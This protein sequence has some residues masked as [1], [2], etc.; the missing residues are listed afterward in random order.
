MLIYTIHPNANEPAIASILPGVSVARAVE[1]ITGR[2]P[3]QGRLL[4]R[5]ARSGRTSRCCRSQ[6]RCVTDLTVTELSK[7]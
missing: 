1:S 5:R 6:V 2:A 7:R 3:G 4:L